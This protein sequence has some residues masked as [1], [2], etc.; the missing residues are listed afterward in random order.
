MGSTTQLSAVNLAEITSE[1]RIAL[2]KRWKCAQESIE[3]AMERFRMNRATVE[4]LAKLTL[5]EIEVIA[6]CGYSLFILA[7]EEKFFDLAKK[8][9]SPG[10]LGRL[11]VLQHG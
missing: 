6:N 10:E 4:S 2:L 9:A 5:E 11:M 3:D 8:V 7:C 1:N